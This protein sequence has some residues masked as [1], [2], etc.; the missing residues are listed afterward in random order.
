MASFTR[1]TLRHRR[2]IALFW[3]LVTI[4]GLASSGAA[5]NAL[6]KQFPLPGRESFETDQAIVQTYGNGGPTAPLV[7]VLVLPA[8]VTVA[9]PGVR[10]QLAHAFAQMQAAMPGARIVSYATTG[11]RAFVS[12]DGRATFG[13]IFAPAVPGVSA[14]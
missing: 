7:P 2:L 5:S 12:R 9:T 14:T 10:A 13:L 4:I 3:L 1:W 8:G 11:D 6:S